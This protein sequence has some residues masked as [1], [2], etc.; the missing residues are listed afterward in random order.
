MPGSVK[1]IIMLTYTITHFNLA[2]I[3]S[4]DNSAQNA[5]IHVTEY[6]DKNTGSSKNLTALIE[7]LQSIL[8]KRSE[9]LF[10]PQTLTREFFQIIQPLASPNQFLSIQIIVHLTATELHLL[11]QS[12]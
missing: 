10:I 7:Y 4:F 8:Q 9:S 3:Q 1:I 5:I 12:Y 6:S 11:C 2:H